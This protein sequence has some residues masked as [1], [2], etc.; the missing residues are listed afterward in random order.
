MKHY[1]DSITEH[2]ETPFL[3]DTDRQTRLE[4]IENR[5]FNKVFTKNSLQIAQVSSTSYK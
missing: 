5:I 2:E 3:I 1:F 4:I